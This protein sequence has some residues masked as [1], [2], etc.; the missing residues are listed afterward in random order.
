MIT[1][2]CIA[3]GQAMM[4]SHTEPHYSIASWQLLVAGVMI[5]LFAIIKLTRKW[6]WF[7]I[8]AMLVVFAVSYVQIV[9]QY[10]CCSG[11]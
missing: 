1:I 6:Y 3:N 5:A 4:V 7:S 9:S 11:G 2:Y 10:P 8:P